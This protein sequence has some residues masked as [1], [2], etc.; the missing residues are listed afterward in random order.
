M[1]IL[2]TGDRGFIGSH[3]RKQL[4]GHEIIGIDMKE[5]TNILTYDLPKVDLVIHLAAQTNVIESTQDPSYD[6]M[7]NI[8]GT[9]RLVNHYKDTK[10]IFASSGGA[11]QETIES[12]Y[13]MSKFCA[14]GYIKLISNNYVILRFPNVFGPG[15]NS[16]VEKF[17]HGDIRI[18]GD[19]TSTR[20]YVF[21][22]DIVRAIELSFK[23][24]QG[25]YSL[26]SG[27][28]I[29]VLELAEATGKPIEF[30][31][32]IKGELHHSLVPNNT[33]WKPKTDVIN[34]IKNV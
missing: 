20:D 13:G 10:F 17:I 6:A 34:Y 14:E 21:V 2:I 16:V 8:V 28:S 3:L 12:P 24:K 29:S 19:G 33:K 5:G 1:K 4:E 22:A 9:I 23:W 31:D 26:G 25:T 30:T 15:S 32:A 27:K 18:F 11:I 7:T